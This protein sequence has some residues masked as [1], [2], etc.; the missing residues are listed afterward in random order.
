VRDEDDRDAL[1]PEP[2]D[3]PEQRLHLLL[4][5]GGRRLV[6]DHQLRLGGQRPGE[7]GHLLRRDRVLVQRPGD[8]DVDVEPMQDR[9]RLAIHRAPVDET[10]ALGLPVEEHVLCY[11]PER[12]Q[13]DLLVDGR[14]ARQLCLVRR[15][16]RD[17]A[18]VE[19][20]AAGVLGV[21]AGE[22]LDQG[23]LAGAV[24]ADQR[25]H[26]PGR[27]LEASLPQRR[28]AQELLVDA[29]HRQQG[30]GTVSHRARVLP[31]ERA[32]GARGV[33]PGPGGGGGTPDAAQ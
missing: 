28:Y 10:E 33:A 7:G 8:V 29:L 32:A 17:L 15:G 16:E 31:W 14:Q 23:R 27:H 25:V 12:D 21:D 30:G 13:V 11:G 6:H 5:E 1:A 18:S 9:R 24:L 19:L 3:D 2:A 22:H 26:L 20:D 4:G